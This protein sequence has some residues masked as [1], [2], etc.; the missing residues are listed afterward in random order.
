VA[1]RPVGAAEASVGVRE[2]VVEVVHGV[3]PSESVGPSPGIGGR[4]ASGGAGDG[5]RVVEEREGLL[6]E[7]GAGVG[8]AGQFDGDQALVADGGEGFEYGREVDLAVTEGEVF[9]D[10]APH[11]LDLDVA[12]P[13]GGGAYAVGG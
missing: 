5:G 10:A 8:V 3:L 1:V 12:Q 2:G 13:G 11:V 7:L 9:V 4:S 6:G